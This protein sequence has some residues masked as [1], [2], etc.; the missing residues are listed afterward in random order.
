[1]ESRVGERERKKKL[2]RERRDETQRDQHKE[3]ICVR[4]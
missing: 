3:E 1:M 4:E 2:E